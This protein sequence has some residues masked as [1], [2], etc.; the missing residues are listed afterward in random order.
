MISTHEIYTTG[1]MQKKKE[2]HPENELQLQYG[3][4]SR[5]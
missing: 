3:I 2:T 1:Y 5:K 4:T